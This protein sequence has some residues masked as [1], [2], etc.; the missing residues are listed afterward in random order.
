MSFVLPEEWESAISDMKQNTG[1]WF[2]L[3]PSAAAQG[4]G[5]VFVNEPQTVPREG[6]YM[7]SHYVNNPYL[8]N[9]YKFDLRIYVGITSINPL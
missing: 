4:K 9:G 2:I 5:I 1:K 3:K 7:M 6:S 8:I